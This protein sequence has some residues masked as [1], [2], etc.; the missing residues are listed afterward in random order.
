MLV[1]GA[2]GGG[3]TQRFGSGALLTDERGR[4]LLGIGDRNCG[5]RRRADGLRR[6]A[7]PAWWPAM[8]QTLLSHRR[9]AIQAGVSAGGVRRDPAWGLAAE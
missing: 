7:R 5:R 1:T 3:R 4:F 2:L 8:A 9:R 6:S